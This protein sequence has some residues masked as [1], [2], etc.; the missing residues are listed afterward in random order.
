VLVGKAVEELRGF[1]DCVVAVVNAW[2]KDD[3]LA[4]KETVLQ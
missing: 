4:A 1:D 2:A 3:N